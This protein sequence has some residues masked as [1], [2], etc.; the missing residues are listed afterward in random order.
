MRFHEERSAGTF[1]VIVFWLMGLVMAFGPLII[2]AGPSEAPNP[3]PRPFYLVY[4]MTVLVFSGLVYIPNALDLTRP[5]EVRR[6]LEAFVAIASEDS[7]LVTTLSG[8]RPYART[9]HQ[10]L[11]SLD[12]FFNPERIRAR[13]DRPILDQ[14]IREAGREGGPP[15]IFD[16]ETFR[17]RRGIWQ[18]QPLSDIPPEVLVFQPIRSGDYNFFR[19][20]FIDPKTAEHYANNWDLYEPE[21]WDG[22]LVRWTK[23][24]ARV[25]FQPQAGLLTVSYW[26]G[27]PDVS[28]DSP[29]GIDL[30]IGEQTLDSSD[31]GEGGYFER[32]LDISSF[33]GG[34]LELRITVD[35]TWLAPEGRRLG[36]GLYPLRFEEP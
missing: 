18:V 24:E 2:R 14:W 9:R 12:W 15:V 8:P 4:G 5:D 6:R 26:I 3:R 28:P 25:A 31:H 35:R 36:V 32:K 16:E 17:R 21:D 22:T 34:E 23:R 13:W 19:L 7:R 1:P 30:A 10:T 33:G 29:V 27:H 11:W 20:R